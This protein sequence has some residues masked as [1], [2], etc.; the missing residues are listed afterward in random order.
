MICTKAGLCSIFLCNCEEGT[1]E[2]ALANR[3]Q[4]NCRNNHLPKGSSCDKFVGTTPQETARKY[5]SSNRALANHL[6][7]AANAA[8]PRVSAN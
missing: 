5:S 4:T 2:Y 3:L 1:A 7:T 6:I 8:F